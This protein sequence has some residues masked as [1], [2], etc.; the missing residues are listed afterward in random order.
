M[1]PRWSANSKVELLIG[2]LRGFSSKV[3]ALNC[4]ATTKRRRC[5][6]NLG[7]ESVS[8]R[9]DD[10]AAELSHPRTDKFVAKDLKAHESAGSS[11]SIK[12]AIA[13]NV[14]DH[15]RS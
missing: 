1:S 4:N 9:F 6:R 8:G 11:R 3:L 13:S 2:V 15:Y 10:A 7:Q 5:A 12:R 14:R